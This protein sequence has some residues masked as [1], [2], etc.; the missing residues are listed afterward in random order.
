MMADITSPLS[1][2]RREAVVVVDAIHVAVDK[3]VALAVAGA[4]EVLPN[5]T[6]GHPL[7]QSSVP[8]LQKVQS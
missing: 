6:T 2:L 4:V 5:S 3:V 7:H 1:T 8:N